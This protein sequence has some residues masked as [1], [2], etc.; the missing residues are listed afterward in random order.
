MP[1]NYHNTAIKSPCYGCDNHGNPDYFDSCANDCRPL[2][3]YLIFLGDKP[4][5]PESKEDIAKKFPPQICYPIASDL[6]TEEECRKLS[7]ALIAKKKELGITAQRISDQCGVN[8]SLV[9]ALCRHG[10]KRTVRENYR[11]LWGWI[12][13]KRT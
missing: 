13:D 12:N 10:Q 3:N 1:L 11:K 8:V 6:C 7:D 2:N 9:R 4:R 5:E